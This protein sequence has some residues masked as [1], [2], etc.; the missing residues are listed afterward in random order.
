MEM[1]S[2][3]YKAKHPFRFVLFEGGSHGLPE[4]R[5]EVDRLILN[6]FNDYL[7]DGKT[8]PSLEMHGK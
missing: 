5:S 7:R 4:F 6:W 3:L 2:A 8:W 1:A